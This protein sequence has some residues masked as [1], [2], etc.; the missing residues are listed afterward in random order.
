MGFN[1]KK[2]ISNVFKWWERACVDI[3]IKRGGE[4]K[5]KRIYP[6]TQKAAV[7]AVDE[8]EK[9]NTPKP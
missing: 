9:D 6:P 7:L 4:I 8:Y 3:R 1:K 2:E 5:K